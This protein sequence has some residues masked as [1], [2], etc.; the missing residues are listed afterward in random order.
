MKQMKEIKYIGKHT[1]LVTNC[2]LQLYT[3]SQ[4]IIGPTKSQ[5]NNY[6]AS[7]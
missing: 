6:T 3:K 5:S 7:V 1:S 4:N 2:I